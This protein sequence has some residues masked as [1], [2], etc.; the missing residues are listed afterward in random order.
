M[1]KVIIINGKE[2]Q[3]V[4]V[5]KM[6]RV[7]NDIIFASRFSNNLEIKNGKVDIIRDCF[8]LNGKECISAKLLRTEHERHA[9]FNKKVSAKTRGRLYKL[10]IYIKNLIEKYN[11]WMHNM[12]PSELMKLE[13]MCQKWHIDTRLVL[14]VLSSYSYEDDI[15][16]LFL[17]PTFEF[18]VEVEELR[19]GKLLRNF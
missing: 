7:K 8:W 14:K 9:L 3:M 15:N 11:G 6:S 18:M 13:T 19:R 2:E 17:P 5:A 12:R 1:K 10:T 4:T 16:H